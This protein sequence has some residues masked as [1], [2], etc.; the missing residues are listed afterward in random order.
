MAYSYENELNAL[1]EAQKKSAIADLENTRNKALSDLQAEQQKNEANYNTQRNTANVQNKL[2]ARNFQEY[3]ASTGRANS[4][5]ASQ[6]KLQSD[7]NL[8]TNLNSITGAQNAALADINRRTTD[9]NNAYNSGLASA[10]ATIE[11]NY[12]QNLLDQRAKAAQ[13]EQQE[14]EFNESVRQFNEQMAY[15]YANLRSGSGSGSRGGGSYSSSKYASGVVPYGKLA[16]AVGDGK[17]NM[18]Y[19]DT[20]GNVYKMKAGY[21][22]YTGTKNSDTSKGYF[23]NGYQP[24]NYRG[25]KLTASGYKGTVNGQTQNVW[26]SETGKYYF[27]DGTTNTYKQLTKAEKK[28][29]GIKD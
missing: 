4:G 17:G 12:I 3:L 7:N 25:S 28:E 21:N 16:S 29:L 9:A 13:L 22:P 14:R 8:A 15:N 18:I 26:K 2:N 27:W 24:N 1:K 23:S 10:N 6:A 11:A 20:D 5:L 19:T